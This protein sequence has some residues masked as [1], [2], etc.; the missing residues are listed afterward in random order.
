MSRVLVWALSLSFLCIACISG[1][2]AQE[3][4]DD[5]HPNLLLIAKPEMTDPRFQES[6]VLVTRH[7]GPGPIGVILNKPTGMHLNDIFSDLPDLDKKTGSIYYGG[8]VSSEILAFMVETESSPKPA[9]TI[10]EHI[11]LALDPDL[12]HNFIL[13][14]EQRKQLRVYSGYSGWAPGQL[15][16]EIERGDWWVMPLRT[17]Y[18]FPESPEKLWNQIVQELRG[19]WVLA[20]EATN[21]RSV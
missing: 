10:A 11:F 16:A 6:V 3:D 14:P 20:P 2:V 19:K 5:A 17:K 13:H 12:L 4:G 1:V 21:L 15:E 18:L 9:L 7:G 8:P